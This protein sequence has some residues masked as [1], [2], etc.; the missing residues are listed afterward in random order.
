MGKGTGHEEKSP[1][2]KHYVVTRQKKLE[3]IGGNG[4]EGRN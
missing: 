4:G 2:K 1:E 3:D